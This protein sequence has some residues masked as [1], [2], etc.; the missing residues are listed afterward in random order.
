MQRMNENINVRV[1]QAERELFEA[2]AKRSRRK[3]SDWVRITLVDS[4]K[5]VV[6]EAD[7]ATIEERLVR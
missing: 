5:V 1:R 3:L 2:A 7:I 6:P 4:A